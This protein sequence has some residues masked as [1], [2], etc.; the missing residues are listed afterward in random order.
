[1]YEGERQAVQTRNIWAVG[2]EFGEPG[3]VVLGTTSLA[4]AIGHPYAA[5]LGM[6]YNQ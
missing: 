5:P 2:L 4:H 1:M 3:A 6:A